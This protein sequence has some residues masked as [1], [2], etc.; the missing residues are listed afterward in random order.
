MAGQ[1]FGGASVAS[2]GGGWWRITLTGTLP[3]A[4]AAAT[5]GV[6]SGGSRTFAGDGTS[7]VLVWG[8]T[9]TQGLDA[10]RP[11][12]LTQGQIARPVIFNPPVALTPG[13]V[14]MWAA[15]NGGANWAGANAFVSYDGSTYE[16]VGVVNGGARFGALTAAFA[17]GSDPDTTHTL[18][19]DLSAS[20]GVIENASQAAADAAGSLCLINDATP[21][22]IA[23]EAVTLTAPNRYNLATYI[24]RGVEN[25]PIGA[26]G[27][28]APFIRLDQAV[29]D[30]PY[31]ATQAG[32]QVYVKFQSFNA[33]GAAQDLANCIAYPV[34]PIPLGAR[35]PTSSAWTATP[36]TISNGGTSV[37]AILI[38]G[39]S[40][41]LSASA[42]EFFYRQTGTSAWISG[43]TTSNSAT[44]FLITGVAAGQTYDVAV[45]YVVNGVLG[46]LQIITAGGGST[47]PS[48]GSGG[49][50][51]TALLSDSAAGSGKTFTCPA[52]AYAHADIVLT[53]LAGSGTG[54]Y[55]GG[56]S[57]SFI[58][59]GG[60]GGGA[61]V[62]KGFPVTP[63]TTVFTY[64]LPSAIGSDATCTASGLS[65]TAHSGTSATSGVE[66]T[67]AAAS[68]G[69][70][71]TGAASVTAYA[72]RGG[73]LTDGWDGGG[74]G[75]TINV[76]SGAVTAPGP[77]NTTDGYPGS[78]PGQGGAGSAF[79]GAQPGG[80][81]NLLIIART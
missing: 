44:Q 79:S 60:G 77:D 59:T 8:P 81:C 63:G 35:A 18:S 32:K 58:D 39:H 10:A 27:A 43:G 29:F 76:S 5:L 26:H 56:K 17:S 6:L 46:Q 54:Y 71:A 12:T 25:T 65:L 19:I 68:T 48:G 67:G 61:V 57:G 30:F 69:N 4:G 24:R 23:Y 42:I 78:I 31:L 36:T 74:P 41:N 49:A 15:V 20:E 16:Q 75:A 73:G 9:L 33:W 21:E 34:I 45:A 52:G 66:G 40:D 50:P 1:S 11:F 62:V 38:T 13:G 51:G 7:A 47:T 72:G 2:A 37:P 80:G 55:T 22:L 53:G 14:E 70:S 28:A 3:Q 64:T